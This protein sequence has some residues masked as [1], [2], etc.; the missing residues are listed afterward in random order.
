MEVNNPMKRGAFQF[1]A[2]ANENLINSAGNVEKL[3]RLWLDRTLIQGYYLGP[4]DPGD[5]E[6]GAWHVACHLAGAA[7]VM[8]AANDQVLWL[9]ISHRG[10]CDEYY[11]SVTAA[12]KDGIS[13]VAL[14]SAAGRALV[15][16]ATLLGFVEGNSTGRTSARGVNDSPTLF[17]L[18]RRQDFDQPVN[19][20]AK[21]GGKV[22]EHWCTL[23]DIRSSAPIGTSVLTAYVSLV[24]ALGDRFAPTVARGRRE[25]GHP[26]QLQALVTAGFT[27]A[28]SAL[29]DTTPVPIPPGAE[30]LLLES[31]PPHALEAVKGLD[32]SNCPR[33]YMFDRRIHGWSARDQVQADLSD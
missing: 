2:D 14:D 28:K 4:G 10:V 32:W 31:D 8:R 17:N 23:R 25:Y 20:T 16:G 6:R 12:A 33:Y 30:A 24:A 9:E 19:K 7:G 22:W 29:W 26:D 15:D 3:R 18:W 21:D 13:I 1:E 5:F 27:T 11:A